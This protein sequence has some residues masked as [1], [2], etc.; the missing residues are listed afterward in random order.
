MIA[1]NDAEYP[2]QYLY[3]FI[4]C[5]FILILSTYLIHLPLAL[6][7]AQVPFQT[8]H[9]LV[10]HKAYPNYPAFQN[11]PNYPKVAY[12][13]D[14]YAFAA[15]DFVRRQAVR[16]KESR[17]PFFGLFAA[18][19]PHAPFKEVEKLPNWDQAYKDKPYFTKLSAQS[20][21]LSLIHI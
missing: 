21:Q 9:L 5:C 3:S 14:V 17:E 20:R 19:I 12:C 7:Q 15:L 8:L 18:Q 11:H 10:L 2:N 13:D 4:H 16:Y 6:P 1:N